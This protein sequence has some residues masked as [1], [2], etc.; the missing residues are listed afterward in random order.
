MIH[1]NSGFSSSCLSMNS[2]QVSAH[3]SDRNSIL[4]Y[5]Y[6]ITPNAFPYYANPQAT[7]TIG[8]V[9]PQ[10]PV[11]NQGVYMNLGSF[12]NN[13]NIPDVVPNE[14]SN[15]IIATQEMPSCSARKFGLKRKASDVDLFSPLPAKIKID[16]A[17][18]SAFMSDLNLHSQTNNANTNSHA[19]WFSTEE[20]PSMDMTGESSS[21][22]FDPLSESQKN[23]IDLLKGGATLEMRDE[24]KL[25]FKSKEILPK[26]VVDEIVKPGLQL[27]LWKPP[28]DGVLEEIK[29]KLNDTNKENDQETPDPKETLHSKESDSFLAYDEMMG[30]DINC[31]EYMI[32]DDMDMDP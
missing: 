13:F 15:P 20:S 18:M 31:S 9:C 17:K 22:S 16:E 2:Y 25:D 4:Q 30:E 32:E 19:P 26:S 3:N 6:Q 21:T 1:N 7:P 14:S 27:V 29:K 11:V 5:P 24:F 10:A 23:L 8:Y 28:G 12:P